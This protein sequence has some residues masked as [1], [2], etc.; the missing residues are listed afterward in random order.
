MKI[1]TLVAVLDIGSNSTMLTIST[2]NLPTPEMILEL[3]EVTSLAKGVDKTGLLSEDAMTR[4]REIIIQFVAQAKVFGV[5][6]FYGTA[7]SAVR[8]A[9]NGKLFIDSI[10]EAVGFKPEILEGQEEADT[11]F[12][13]TTADLAI[14]TKVITCDPGGGSTEINIGIVGQAPF[15][16]KS[17][18][19]GCVRQGDRFNLYEESSAQ[20]ITAAREEIKSILSEA[21]SQVDSAEY[22][23]VI[24]AGTA[25][26][27][28][29]ME[30]ELSV[31]DRDK[32]H[33]SEGKQA[34]LES[35]ITELFSLTIIERRQIPSIGNR[36]A[37]IPSGLLIMSEVLKGFNKQDFLISAK[38]LRHGVLLK[39]CKS[40]A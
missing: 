1:S 13:G 12:L 6:H 4:T 38:A 16:G 21:F 31:Y 39:A 33:L 5:K 8:D 30:L 37:T 17:F 18:D 7:T 27:Y 23:L 25:T 34:P 2:T 11:V 24:S 29:A 36:A 3:C 28:G 14:G 10:F 20:D 40:L 26:T 19:V 22:Q 15:Y 32:V 9:K 35:W